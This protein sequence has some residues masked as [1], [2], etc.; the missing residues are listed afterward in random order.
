MLVMNSMKKLLITIYSVNIPNKWEPV[1]KLMINHRS[2]FKETVVE[3]KERDG[4]VI[5]TYFFNHIKSLND[6][7][8]SLSNVFDHE[9]KPFKIQF[10]LSGYLNH[11]L[12]DQ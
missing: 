2:K 4:K 10:Y 1:D 11:Q 8:N 6:I 3:E 9:R 5:V 12:M 7:F